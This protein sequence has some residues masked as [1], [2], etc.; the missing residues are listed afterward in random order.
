MYVSKAA[1]KNT[2]TVSAL[3]HNPYESNKPWIRPDEIVLLGLPI[4]D[5]QHL[6]IVDMLNS[7]DE[8]LKHRDSIVQLPEM[9]E[10]LVSF[11]DYHF[12]T[13]ERLMLE[14]GYPE[15]VEH[16]NVHEHLLQELTHLKE[17]FAQGGELA[18]LQRLKDWFSLHISSLDKPLADFIRRH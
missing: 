5:E 6:K 17:R 8:A 4:I 13:E 3:N 1:G 16:Q 11:T 2:Y 10:A 7:L 12:K 18:L 9:L 15:V 14:Y